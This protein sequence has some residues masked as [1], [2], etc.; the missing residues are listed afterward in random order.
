MPTS[1][2][3]FPML[4][5]PTEDIRDYRV[6]RAF[7][8]VEK[9]FD[10][11]SRTMAASE[12]DNLQDDIV[13]NAKLAD[14]AID[15]EH[16]AALAVEFGKILEGAA[17]VKS[18]TVPSTITKTGMTAW[19]DLMSI[20]LETVGEPAYFAMWME[21][22][23]D[24]GSD[25]T[26]DVRI[27]RVGASYMSHREYI[28]PTGSEWITWLVAGETSPGT[29]GSPSSNTYKVQAQRVSG[30][31]GS[32]EFTFEKPTFYGEEVRR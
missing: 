15:T 16:L 8:E 4:R 23:H 6:R 12:E 26:I 20:T 28:V 1:L 10:A 22:G 32:T 14:L 7:E 5:V 30:G 9:Y 21:A 17:T 2:A 31:S 13:T 11:F 3:S 25:V 29:P 27:L 24:E 18:I 19:T